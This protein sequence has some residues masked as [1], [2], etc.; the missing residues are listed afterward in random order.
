MSRVLA[1]VAAALVAFSV[2]GG[3][4]QAS[5]VDIR[6][7]TSDRSFGAA[8][9]A[10]Y[11]DDDGDLRRTISGPDHR[12]GRDDDDDRRYFAPPGRYGHDGRDPNRYYGRPVPE[13]HHWDRYSYNRP[14]FARPGWRHDDCRIVL[15]RKVKP[16]GQVVITQRQVCD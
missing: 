9:G 1:K 2:L 11:R 5:G 3:A 4:A 16:W 15:Q 12:Y 6:I 13:R 8:P 10:F 14:V 7:T